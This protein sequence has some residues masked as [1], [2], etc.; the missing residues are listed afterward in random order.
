MEHNFSSHCKSSSP[1][2]W[3]VFEIIKKEEADGDVVKLVF[4]NELFL[5]HLS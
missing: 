1:I 2:I 4:M 5:N 3:F